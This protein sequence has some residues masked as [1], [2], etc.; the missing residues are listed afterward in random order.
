MTRHTKLGVEAE[1][2]K[3]LRG[4]SRVK[5]KIVTEYFVAYNRVMAPGSKGQSRLRGLVRRDRGRY[6]NCR[7]CHGRNRFP[8][9]SV[10]QPFMMNFSVKR[11][12]SGST[13][14]TQ[15]NYHQ[16]NAAAIKSVPERLLPY[17][18]KP[19]ISAT[20]SSILGGLAN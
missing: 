12:T 16:L 6:R 8:F 9:W 14:V 10:R 5:Q 13:K 1:F 3:Q 7:R 17:D 18:N 19:T 2:F 11:F 15:D 4:G 20:V